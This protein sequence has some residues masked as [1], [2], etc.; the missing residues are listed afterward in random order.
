MPRGKK[1]PVKRKI[2]RKRNNPGMSMPHKELK[3]NKYQ[4]SKLMLTTNSFEGVTR[5]RDI[6]VEQTAK[7]LPIFVAIVNN[8][9]S[10]SQLLK[11]IAQIKLRM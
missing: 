4:P 6:R 1:L 7:Y 10:L 11:E 9:S 3:M 5:R 8:F 2:K